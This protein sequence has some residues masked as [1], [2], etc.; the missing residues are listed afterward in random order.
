MAQHPG[1]GVAEQSCVVD[2]NDRILSRLKAQAL[3]I[4]HTI[5]TFMYDTGEVVDFAIVSARRRAIELCAALK[6]GMGQTKR[7]P[8]LRDAL[9]GFIL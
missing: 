2:M 4:N 8:L 7:A 6:R 3:T 9:R 5:R 1:P